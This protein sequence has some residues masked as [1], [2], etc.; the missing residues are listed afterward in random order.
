MMITWSAFLDRECC[1]YYIIFCSWN[2]IFLNIF[3][4][5]YVTG[6]YEYSYLCVSVV[7]EF[8]L[9]LHFAYQGLSSVD[10][11]SAN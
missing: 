9:V 5:T 11:C 3:I 8:S 4:Y 6:E 10:L 7:S 2:I 1:D